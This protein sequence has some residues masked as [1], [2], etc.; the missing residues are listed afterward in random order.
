MNRYSSVGGTGQ[1]HDD[2]GNLTD[3][4]TN[5]YAYDFYNRLVKVTRKGDSAVLAVYVYDPHGRRVRRTVTNSGALNGVTHYVY[6]GPMVIEEHAVTDPGAEETLTQIARYINGRGIDERIVMERQD[7]ADVDDDANTTELQRFYYHTDVLNSVRAVTWWDGTTEHL[8][9]RVEYD[10]YGKQ[11]IVNWGADRTFG[12]GD[13][14]TSST[15]LVGNPYLFTGREFD[16]ESGLY[17]YRLR[18]YQ[19]ATGRFISQDPAGYIDGANMYDYVGGIRSGIR[20]L[21]G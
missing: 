18:Y 17:N 1:V 21:G 8:V 15:S 16:P 3:D 6:D 19:P 11:T 9:E 20:T 4:G 12:T 7:V 2:N 14:A 5:L 13:D 10:I